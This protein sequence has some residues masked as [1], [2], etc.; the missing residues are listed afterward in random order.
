MSGSVA[1][2]HLLTPTDSLPFHLQFHS[3]ALNSLAQT[4][5]RLCKVTLLF[6]PPPRSFLYL[7]AQHLLTTHLPPVFPV[8]LRGSHSTCP[9][10]SLSCGPLYWPCNNHPTTSPPL[11]DT[12]LN[13]HCGSQFTNTWANFPP[14]HPSV[15]TTDSRQGV[16]EGKIR[17]TCQWV[18]VSFLDDKMFWN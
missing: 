15:K 14:F 1:T 4:P 3:W 12:S 6:T 9:L 10:R 2:I 5:G 18:R 7:S 11:S 8:P 13:P 17:R 16:G